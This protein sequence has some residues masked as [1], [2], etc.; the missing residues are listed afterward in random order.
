MARTDAGGLIYRRKTRT[1]SFGLHSHIT[2]HAGDFMIKC[3]YD[4]NAICLSIFRLNMV[5][6]TIMRIRL[7]V[8]VM[9][10]ARCS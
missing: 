2:F 9:S 7:N 8:S 1:V 10:Q 4:C 3:C 6:L 5:D